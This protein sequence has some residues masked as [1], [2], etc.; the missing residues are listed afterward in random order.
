MTHVLRTLLPSREAPAG[1]TAPSPVDRPRRRNLLVRLPAASLAGVAAAGASAPWEQR[2]LLPL[3][4]AALVLV[5]QR[6]SLRYA[7]L[8]GLLFG[9]GFTLA[10]TAWMRAVGAAAWRHL[11]SDAALIMLQELVLRP[12]RRRRNGR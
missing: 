2:W 12:G 9:L 3:A 10:L 7:S 6:V 11:Q 4:V 8:L 1:E 5:L